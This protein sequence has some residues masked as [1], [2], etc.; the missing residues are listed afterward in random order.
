MNYDK[1][2]LDPKLYSPGITNKL[3]NVFVF[4]RWYLYAVTAGLIIFIFTSNITFHGTNHGMEPDLWTMGATMYLCVVCIVN[5]KILIATNTHNLGSITLFVFSVLSYIIVNLIFTN[6]ATFNVFG[7]W[8]FIFKDYISMFGLILIISCSTIAEYCW[9][10]VHII[11]DNLIIQ[12]IIKYQS[13][14]KLNTTKGLKVPRETVPSTKDKERLNSVDTIVKRGMSSASEVVIVSDSINY[15]S[16]KDVELR[17]DNTN[18]FDMNSV[19]NVKGKCKFLILFRH[20][21]CFC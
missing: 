19:V 2:E 8:D 5:F 11:L 17:T 13:D 9:R 14:K 7:T 1:L 3:F 21:I 20:R 4:W 16:N 6:F 15:I 10:S 12:R 18:N